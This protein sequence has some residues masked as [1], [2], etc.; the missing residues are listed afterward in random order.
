LITT[1]PP[2]PVDEGVEEVAFDTGDGTEDETLGTTGEAVEGF[3]DGWAGWPA[4]VLD[5]AF[6]I[7]PGADPPTG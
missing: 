5:G 2:T 6:G 1:L 4:G 7:V 3:T